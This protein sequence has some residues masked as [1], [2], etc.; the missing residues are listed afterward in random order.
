MII[1]NILGRII[2]TFFQLFYKR[3]YITGLENIP[4]DKPIFFAANHSN[5]LIDGFMVAIFLIGYRTCYFLGRASIFGNK[6]LDWLFDAVQIIP[7]YRPRDGED[8]TTKNITTFQKVDEELLKKKAIL[9]FPEGNCVMERRLRPLKKGTVRMSFS[10]WEKGADVHII[11]TGINYTEHNEARSEVMLSFGKPIRIQDYAAQFEQN[12]AATYDAVNEDLRLAIMSEMVLVEA[13]E[14]DELIQRLLEISRNDFQEKSNAIMSNNPDRLQMEREIASRINHL[15][16]DN[17]QQLEILRSKTTAYFKT[18]AAFKTTDKALVNYEQSTSSLIQLIAPLAMAL[19]V[20]LHFPLRIFKPLA[21]KMTVNE[22]TMF[23]TIWTGF[24]MGFYLLLA[25][26]LIT[27]GITTI[28][29]WEAV[30]LGLGIAILTFGAGLILEKYKA[31]KAILS[32]KKTALASPQE[33]AA[34]K[35]MRLDLKSLS[36][37]FQ[38]QSR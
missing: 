34:L 35:E 12:P 5:A 21:Q 2:R 19:S 28:P 36:C 4:K 31:D 17:K 30:S 11:P 7:I 18:L 23:V 33:I 27:L 6:I 24:V 37:H 9:I 8:Y 14:N 26:L 25:I 20:I 3:I 1:Y 22:P 29:L 10:A 32:L 16:R 13:D 38:E 15:A